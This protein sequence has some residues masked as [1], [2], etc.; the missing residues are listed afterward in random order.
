MKK[1]CCARDIEFVSSSLKLIKNVLRD[2]KK[3]ITAAEE[4]NEH[5]K[6]RSKDVAKRIAEFL[7]QGQAFILKKIICALLYSLLEHYV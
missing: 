2:L 1:G 3:S 6:T 7:T 5:I 4:D